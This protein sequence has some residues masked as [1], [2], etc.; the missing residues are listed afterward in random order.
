MVQSGQ[1]PLSGQS[2]RRTNSI[3][4]FRSNGPM[5]T[6]PDPSSV[7]P[8]FK[9]FA[10]FLDSWAATDPD[11]MKLL[12]ENPWSAVHGQSLMSFFRAAIRLQEFICWMNRKRRSRRA[13]NLN[14]LRFWGKQQGR[15][16]P[17]IIATH[18]PILLACPEARIYILIIYRFENN[19]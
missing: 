13:V 18:S 17:F 12:G 8:I 2:F 10:N 19:L 5:A 7:R 4:T 6:C 3:N 9:D 14:Y 15:T 16:C 1:Q 11:C